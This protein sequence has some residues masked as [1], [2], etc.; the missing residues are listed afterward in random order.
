[1]LRVNTVAVYGETFQ[2]QHF[3]F[4]KELAELICI[5]ITVGK[6]SGVSFFCTFRCDIYEEKSNQELKQLVTGFTRYIE[7]LNKMR[8]TQTTRQQKAKVS[9]F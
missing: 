5:V 3:R 4:Y 9:G 1:M 2:R 8:R 7:I 6:N